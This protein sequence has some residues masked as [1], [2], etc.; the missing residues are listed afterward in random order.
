MPSMTEFFNCSNE[1]DKRRSLRNNMPRAEVLLWSRLQRRQLLGC[2]FRRQYSVGVYVLDFY[3]PEVKLGIE[4]DGESHFQQ[5]AQQHDEQRRQ[6][7]ENFGIKILRF[8]NPDVFDS[9]DGVLESIA[10]ELK[11]RLRRKQPPPA[12][13]FQG[14]EK[15]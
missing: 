1:K 11:F 13:P 14:G 15:S 6:F 8:L 5:G 3:C 7:I 10:S 4:L 12:P 9:L 2:R